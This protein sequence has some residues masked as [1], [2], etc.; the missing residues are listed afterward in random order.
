ML[1]MTLRKIF[2]L[3]PENPSSVNSSTFLVI[4]YHLFSTLFLKRK[5]FVVIDIFY[6]EF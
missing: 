4:F 5:D 2:L 3:E 1:Y 6:Y